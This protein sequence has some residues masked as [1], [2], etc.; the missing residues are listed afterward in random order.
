MHVRDAVKTLKPY[1]P[2]MTLHDLKRFHL[3]TCV[4]LGS[5]ENPLGPAPAVRE[6][7]LRS[8]DSVRL[9]PEPGAPRL[10]QALARHYRRRVEETIAGAGIDDLLDLTVRCLLDPGDNLVLA[11]PGFVRYA[12]AASLAGGEARLVPGP[13]GSPYV[14]DLDAMLAAVNE[15]TRIVVLVNP[16]NPTGSMFTRSELA[17]FLERVPPRVLTVLDEA[18][19][20]F[21]DDPGYPDGL[22]FL[23][24]EKPLLVFRTFS[25]IHSLAG[26]RVGFGFGPPELV[27]LLDRARLPFNVSIPAQEAAVAALDQDDHV[28]KSA[29][30]ARSETRFLAAALAGRGWATEPTWTNFVFAVSPFPGEP[31]VEGLLQRGFILRPLTGFGLGDRFFRISHGTRPQNEAFVAALDAFTRDAGAS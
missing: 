7:I 21:V 27:E 12:V 8:L 20:E 18:Y 5:N 10:R 2:G 9:Y 25:K 24:G 16:N 3:T 28:R 1:R 13:E 4:K 15:R 30:L 19:F 23:G 6:A 31:L 26:I 14:H 11:H 29:A 17:A 22:D